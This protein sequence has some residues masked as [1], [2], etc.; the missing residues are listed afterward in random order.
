M[1]WVGPED[2]LCVASC[3]LEDIQFAYF[4][5]ACDKYNVNIR[6]MELGR[7]GSV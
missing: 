6:S 5:H 4:C 3:L 2:E 1:S 7:Q